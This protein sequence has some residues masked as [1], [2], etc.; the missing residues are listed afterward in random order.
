[1]GS[2]NN[3]LKR[4]PERGGSGS[5]KLP[6]CLYW[7]HPLLLSEFQSRLS[8]DQFRLKAFQLDSYGSPDLEKVSYP[9]ASLYALESHPR[10]LVTESIVSAFARRTKVARVLVVGERFRE[11]DAFPLLRLGVKGL[12]KYSELPSQLANAARVIA[13][14]GFWVPRTLLSAF[15]DQVSGSSRDR[16]AAVASGDLT[17][18]E[19]QVLEGL[20]QNLLNKEIAKNL[21]ISERTAKF[22]VSNLLA[23]YGVRRRADLILLGSTLRPAAP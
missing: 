15:L 20:L 3:S 7:F 8:P 1:V 23:K 11:S 21:R 12:L 16:L 14:G 9:P 10:R 22:H 5:R 4:K 2:R 17:D 19:R 18:R 13:T 6:V